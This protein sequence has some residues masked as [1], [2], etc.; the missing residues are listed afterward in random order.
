MASASA[1]CA[2]RMVTAGTP[3]TLAGCAAHDEKSDRARPCGRSPVLPGGERRRVLP[4]SSVGG[5]V[6]PQRQRGVTAPT[7]KAVRRAEGR[8]ELPGAG[9]RFAVPTAAW[10]AGFCD[11][12]TPHEKTRFHM[13]ANS[14]S[15]RLWRHWLISVV[16]SRGEGKR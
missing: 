9:Q 8:R 10:S 12:P 15:S 13:N 14:A 1:A 3:V 4:R 2:S 16:Y 5:L 11:K 7:L 6:E